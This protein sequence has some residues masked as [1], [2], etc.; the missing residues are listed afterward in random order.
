MEL[1][2][3]LP[4]DADVLA[5]IHRRAR[6]EAMPWL[7]VLHSLDADQRYFA[8]NV[9]ANDA[10]WVAQDGANVVGFVATSADWVNHLYVQPASWRRGAGS[11]LIGIAKATSSSLQLWTFQQN[12][13]ARRF[14]AAHGF[15]EAEFTDGRNNEEKKADVR[16][17]WVATR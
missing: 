12:D 15:E 6:Q 17:T 14:Y 3:A 11:K 2:K 13:M 5:G 7:P 8:N 1:R 4:T 10:V 16:L 9:L